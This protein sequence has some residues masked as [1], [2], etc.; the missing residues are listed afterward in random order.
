[1]QA[2]RQFF[3]HRLV[4]LA[5]VVSLGIGALFARA[6]WTIRSDEWNYATQTNANL[7]HALEHNLAWTLRTL[8]STL[9]GVAQ[10]LQRPEV[11]RMAPA[12][13][14]RLLFDTS[15]R[16]PG[17]GSMLVLDTQGRV[18]YDSDEAAGRSSMA[19]APLS[20]ADRDYFEA[21]AR[22]QHEGLFIGTPVP[23][24][25]T[26]LLILP[27]ARAW[28]TPDGAFGGVVT[29]AI[30]L[31]YLNE[32]FGTLDLGPNSGINLFRADGTVIVRFPYGDADVGKNIGGTAN[33]R[34]FQ[35]APQG[36]TI[37][38]A[39]LDGVER[40]YAWRHVQGYPLIL[41]VAQSTDAL[42]ATWYRSALML[43]G[44]AL[45]LM[46]A[47]VGLAWL[48]VRELQRRQQTAAQL[49]E[50]E[51]DLRTMLHNLPSLVSYWDVSL[52]NRY[53]NSAYL[54]WFGLT[55]QQLKGMHIRDLLGAAQYAVS[56]PFLQ[57]TLQGERQLF[58]RTYTDRK[59]RLRYAIVS[60]VPDRE[61]TEV[62]GVFAQVTDISDRKRMEDELF[63][64]KELVRLTLQS[65]GDAVVCVDERG[66]VT[67]L[68]PVA[69]RLTGCQGF[70]AADRPL[71]EVLQLRQPDGSP[72]S[73]SP[74]RRAL[75]EGVAVEPTRCIVLGRDGLQ[76]FVVEESASPIFDRH[77][78]VKGAVAVLR[79]VTD[80]VAMAERMEHLAQYDALTDLPNRVLLQDRA[81][82]AMAQARRD[83]RSLAVVYLDLD[84]FKAVNDTY[85]HE[86]GDQLLV[87]FARRL[88][89]AVR[90]SD[91]VC[92]QG[93]DEFVLLMPGLES[94]E[95]LGALARKLLAVCEQPFELTGGTVCVGLS[96]GVSLFPEHGHTLDEL[97]RHADA[98]MYAAKQGGR[99]QV[100]LFAGEGEPPTLIAQ[101]PGAP[102][103]DPGAMI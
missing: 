37:G 74:L 12:L 18:R 62:R 81:R 39:A 98:A 5:F 6:I 65:I 89:A 30:R 51:R 59:G 23:S 97:S 60:Y 88:S 10:E 68:N 36:L 9:E 85:G 76:R 45:F 33:M 26:G 53:A 93:G 8:D 71:D 102:A 72:L 73:D 11:H 24:R 103:P 40:L 86:A 16:L 28:R 67:Y 90:Q 56:E 92:R 52:H 58:E 29:A 31:G 96:A 2:L 79:D 80:A 38:R 61:G 34:V 66:R 78:Q 19:G 63:E 75:A 55:P 91:T 4:W 41:N 7:V 44:F 13:R 84:G 82:Q 14:H 17:L 99:Q 27:V 42:L 87:Q 70:D 1:M 83:G 35:S 48:F 15:L 54:E 50:A 95:L 32:L 94:P 46:A 47:C 64:E 3:S 43:G 100:R 25:I 57:R 49:R 69:E 101:A 22:Q 21:F 20:F 77:H